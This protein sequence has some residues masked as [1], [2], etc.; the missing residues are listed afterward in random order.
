MP[1]R[2]AVSLVATPTR[3]LAAV[4]LARETEQRGFG[5]I[6]I[7]SLGGGS[8][9]QAVSIAHATTSIPFWTSI[10]P[11]Y[12]AH[13]NEVAALASYAGEVSGGRF[14]LGLGVSHPP[15]MKRVGAAMSRPRTEM[16]EFVR[17]MQASSRFTGELPPIWLAALRDRMLETAAEIA[18]GTIWANS[19]L[20]DAAAQLARV[21]A[22]AAE[23]F[24]RS[25]MI[26]TVIS[27]DH[28]A[29]LA[30][31]RKTMTSY[32]VM[33]SYRAYWKA[34]GYVE[35]ME[36]IEA[37]LA[38]GDRSAITGPM[39]ERWLRDVTAFGTRDEV[40][41]RLEAWEDLGITPIAVMSS[42][43]GGQFA[44]IRELFDAFGPA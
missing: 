2:P 1:N 9:A 6:A 8:L 20:S 19:C 33:P 10:H 44:A 26:P 28:A 13:A 42:T 31:H 17:A 43:S 5:G 29:A 37:L 24:A 41:E 25:V 12:H 21:P 35:E 22:A 23:G 18:A 14:R 15:M 38:A 3:R 7:P 16:I 27:D 34:C 36:A 4:E 32:V 11:I 30:V 39:S 40:F